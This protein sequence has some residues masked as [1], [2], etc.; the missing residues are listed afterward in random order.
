M[1]ANGAR[2]AVYLLLDDMTPLGAALDAWFAAPP[3]GADPDLWRSAMARPQRY[4]PHMTLWA[5]TALR[6]GVEIAALAAALAGVAAAIPAV[7]IAGF[8]PQ[9]GAR[10]LS[11]RPAAPRP[12]L[13]R[14]SDAV[15]QALDPFR[16]PL[17]GG[18]L[19]R[20]LAEAADDDARARVGR[21]GY[22]HVG[23]GFHPHFT[24]G[25]G[26]D[27]T[28]LEPAAR[29]HFADAMAGETPV[30]GLSLMVEPAPGARFHPLTTAP[31]AA[32]GGIGLSTPRKS[33]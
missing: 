26:R 4:G 7:A 3:G 29:T 27:A 11:L 9:A 5:P 13:R 25:V 19:D 8:A 16:A 22:P 14:L 23:V 17:T 21:W 6:D 30:A 18:A 10:D 20:R 31:F 1:T 15:V 28:A 12:K 24:L 32:A 2:F 33:A